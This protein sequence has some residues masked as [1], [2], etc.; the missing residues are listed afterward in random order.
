LPLGISAGIFMALNYG[1]I[2]QRKEKNK[3]VMKNVILK[4]CIIVVSLFFACSR[5]YSQERMIYNCEQY[6]NGWDI[7]EWPV[8]EEDYVSPILAVDENFLEDSFSGLKLTVAFDGDEWSAGMI[9]TTGVFDLT[10]YKAI[11]C[12]IYLPESAPRGIMA[13][14]I[15]TVGDDYTWM[16]LKRPIALTPGRH[17]RVKAGLRHGNNGWK[18]TYGGVRIADW[19]KEDVRKIGIRIESNIVEY[20]GPVYIN[21]IR[22]VK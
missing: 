13:R 5:S 14:F 22:L 19:M 15:I 16:E 10:L 8:S 2:K 3:P 6:I 11:S 1:S 21:D 4:M 20:E 18:T 7:P 17:T 9:E 12:R